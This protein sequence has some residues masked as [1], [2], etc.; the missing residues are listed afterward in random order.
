MGAKHG[1]YEGLNGGGMEHQGFSAM[2]TGSLENLNILIH[3]LTHQWFGDK[4]TF[5]T[6]NDLW[7]AEGFAEY[8]PILAAE[9]TSGV[10][11]PYSIRSG[12]RT[13]ARLEQAP[14]RIPNSGIASSG[15][16][17]VYNN[18]TTG[19]GRSV[20]Y[21]GAMVVSMLRTICGD[22]KFFEIMKDYLGSAATKY[23]SANTALLE[24]KF[25]NG[26]G[27]DMAPFFT[28]NVTGTGYP[29]NT[30]GYQ[31]Y[32][33]GNRNVALSVV[34]QT[35]TYQGAAT[36]ITQPVVV[37]VKGALASEKTTIVFYDWGG[38]FL[39]KAGNGVMGPKVPGNTLTFPLTFT[40]TSI[41]YDDSLKTTS[42]GSMT[43]LTLVDFN[44]IDFNV[45]Q[46]KGYNEAVLLMDDNT[47][48]TE[49]I[50]ERSADGTNFEALGN[51]TLQAGGFAGQKIY[52][53]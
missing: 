24:Q 29:T 16:I 1:Y 2:A 23:N 21:R 32:G 10:G 9:L 51:M 17:W 30:I 49:V 19:Y 14:V 50:L 47:T 41:T 31:F 43:A 26:L 28:D 15:T 42:S 18:T 6:W 35:R 20:Y 11:N 45:K 38:G 22:E 27:V 25:T 4:V 44:I 39:S 5:A 53:Q 13:Q 40:P 46:H 7:L 48:N 37:H 52:L 12:I 36:Y 34:N 8:G 3:E 33:T